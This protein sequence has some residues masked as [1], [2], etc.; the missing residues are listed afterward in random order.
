MP[1]QISQ[2]PAVDQVFRVKAALAS[3]SLL[4]V[5]HE[6][7]RSYDGDLEAFV[8]YVA[9]ASGSFGGALRDP[10]VVLQPL[11]APPPPDSAFRPVSR[12][13]IAASTGL[14][15]ETVRRK[16][17]QMIERGHLVQERGGVRARS[18]VL[19]ERRN[20]EFAAVLI[21]EIE[22]SSAEL[23]RVDRM[24]EGVGQS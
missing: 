13:A 20:A 1:E 10:D 9:V 7:V 19:G 14:P 6:A 3:M 24:F 23:A 12:R 22:R 11:D 17:A 16:I 18:G 4:R 21:R 8:I 15:R 2:R 5:M